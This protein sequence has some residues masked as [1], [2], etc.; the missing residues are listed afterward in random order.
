MANP[1]TAAVVTAI[2]GWQPEDV[3]TFGRW[4]N[5]L[6][7]LIHSH[8]T[9]VGNAECWTM[10]L[11]NKGIGVLIEQVEQYFDSPRSG[12]GEIWH[13]IMTLPRQGPV[14]IFINPKEE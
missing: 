14:Y 12:V 5:S 8:E 7:A 13:V 1:V 2:L 10:S 3:V 11:G 6:P 4:C 9:D